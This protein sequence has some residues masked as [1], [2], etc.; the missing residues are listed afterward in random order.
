MVTEFLARFR[1]P[2]W[3][4]ILAMGV[5]FPPQTHL[6]KEQSPRPPGSAFTTSFS[7]AISRASHSVLSEHFFSGSRLNLRGGTESPQ[8][9]GFC[10]HPQNNLVQEGCTEELAVNFC[11]GPKS[12]CLSLMKEAEK[13]ACWRL[14]I[15][16]QT[17]RLARGSHLMVPLKRTGSCRMMDRRERSVCSGSLAMSMPSMMMRPV[18]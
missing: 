15:C 6:R 7:W 9:A 18:W 3:G 5:K 13:E 11:G 12:A 16:A 2:N 8:G 1:A 4:F 17:A 10:L 14:P